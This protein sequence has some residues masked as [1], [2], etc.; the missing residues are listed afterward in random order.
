MYSLTGQYICLVYTFV[1]VLDSYACGCVLGAGGFH[2][3]L[4]HDATP[5]LV[6]IVIL[7]ICMY[8]RLNSYSEIVVFFASVTKVYIEHQMRVDMDCIFHVY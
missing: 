5:P 1:A 8:S 7:L 3:R 4:P 2:L 6:K